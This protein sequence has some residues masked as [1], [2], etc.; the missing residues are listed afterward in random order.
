M[1]DAVISLSQTT[2]PTTEISLTLEVEP[3]PGLVICTSGVPDGIGVGVGV[4][5]GVDVGGGGGM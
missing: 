4:S 3:F 5:S 1:F 2:V